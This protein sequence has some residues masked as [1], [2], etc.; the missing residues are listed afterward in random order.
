M[1]PIISCDNEFVCV[2]QLHRDYEPSADEDEEPEEER[3]VRMELLQTLH[4]VSGRPIWC[5]S[6]TCY[7]TRLAQLLRKY[8]AWRPSRDSR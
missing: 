5:A 7:F 8:K 1:S 4:Q 3:L 2:V 6:P